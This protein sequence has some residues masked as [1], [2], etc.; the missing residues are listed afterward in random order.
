MFLHFPH[1]SPSAL[2]C[3]TTLWLSPPQGGSINPIAL[4]IIIIKDKYAATIFSVNI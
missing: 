3:E 2:L 1:A 4:L